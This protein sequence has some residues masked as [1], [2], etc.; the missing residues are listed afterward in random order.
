M[1]MHPKTIQ[2]FSHQWL[3]GCM[4]GM[5]TVARPRSR[6][7]V[8]KGNPSMISTPPHPLRG[9]GKRR[10]RR[11]AKLIQNCALTVVTQWLTRYEDCHQFATIWRRRIVI[12]DCRLSPVRGNLLLVFGKGLA[13]GSDFQRVRKAC[14]VALVD[15]LCSTSNR[16][17]Y[18]NTIFWLYNVSRFR[19]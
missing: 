19:L 13:P 10:L 7:S 5:V 11:W 15:T 1:T 16:N 8:T 9:L 4:A 14:L 2:W 6:R 12:K 18:Q 17:N 3:F